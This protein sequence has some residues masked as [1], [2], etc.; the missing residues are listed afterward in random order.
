[1]S[2]QSKI[3]ATSNDKSFNV[4]RP[5]AVM[6]RHYY[7]MAAF[8]W[9]C[10]G[11]SASSSTCF[12]TE[13]LG[14]NAKKWQRTSKQHCQSDEGNSRHWLQRLPVLCVSNNDTSL[15]CYNFGKHQPILINFD[16]TLQNVTEFL[17]PLSLSESVT[18]GRCDAR[19]TVTFPA[20]QHCHCPLASAHFRPEEGRRLSWPEWLVIVTHLSTKNRAQ[21]KVTLLMWPTTL[22]NRHWRHM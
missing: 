8:R 2:I 1:M 14:I 3:C 13:H 6:W 22:P 10:V 16:K 20:A 21:R 11:L 18:H 5:C 7:L 12:R 15:T 9:I 4:R 19:P 17:S